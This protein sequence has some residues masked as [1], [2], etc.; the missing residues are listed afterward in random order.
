MSMRLLIFDLLVTVG[1]ETIKAIHRNDI[2][3]VYQKI[4]MY[5]SMKLDATNNHGKAI[6]T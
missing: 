3:Q 6:T 5:V 4:K 1:K 2:V